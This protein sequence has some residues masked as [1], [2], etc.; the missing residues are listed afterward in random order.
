MLVAASSMLLASASLLTS[1]PALR[2]T[3]SRTGAPIMAESNLPLAGTSAGDAEAWDEAWGTDSFAD[4]EL[5]GVW[6]RTGKG[7]KRWAPGDTT[8]DAAVD[9]SLL[10]STWVMNRPDL[11]AR[12]ACPSCTTTRFVLGHLDFPYNLILDA[13]DAPA[14]AQPVL[15][16]QGVPASV[17]DGVG[18]EG[19]LAICSFAAAH[20]RKGIVPPATG[21]PDVTE[22]LSEAAAGTSQLDALA[23]MLGGVHP[24]DQ[25]PCLNPWGFTLDDALVLPY[26]R[27]LK[28]TA[29]DLDEWPA[30]VRAYLEM[31]CARCGVPL[32]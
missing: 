23:A 12:E 16:G 15:D 5:K 25:S 29:A 11:Y 1:G 19:S 26:L 8:G 21:R 13:T 27:N 14:S 7:K 31:S 24:A 2:A 32:I 6:E 17:A 28:P 9:A 30:V 20:A 4:L 3:P 18:L 10:Y 22:W